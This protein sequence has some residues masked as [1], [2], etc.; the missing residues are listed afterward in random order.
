MRWYAQTAEAR[1]NEER[2][3]PV[4][5]AAERRHGLPPGLLR[6]LLYQESRFRTDIITGTL[7]SPAGAVGIAQFMPATAARFGVDPL[8]PVGAIDGAAR[9]LKTLH[10]EFHDWR[11]AVAAYNAGEGN[12]RKYRGVPPFAETQRYVA[13]IGADVKLA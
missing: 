11:L 2:W 3:A 8:D 13:E 5:D 6:R 12:V 9:Y 1:Q 7:R 4:I 10:A